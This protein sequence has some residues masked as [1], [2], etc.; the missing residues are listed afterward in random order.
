MQREKSLVLEIVLELLVV[1]SGRY[2]DPSSS[3]YP[4]QAKN[5]EVAVISGA[6]F[7][8]GRGDGRN[9]ASALAFMLG[10]SDLVALGCGIRMTWRTYMLG[11]I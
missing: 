11:E 9:D 10:R 5:Y 7:L 1:S 3:L 6:T 8:A 2:E 4:L